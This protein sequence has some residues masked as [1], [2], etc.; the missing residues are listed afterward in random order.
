MGIAPLLVCNLRSVVWSLH[1]S[2]IL[3]KRVQ[4]VFVCVECVCPSV[5]FYYR[6]HLFFMSVAIIASVRCFYDSVSHVSPSS[7]TELN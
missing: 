2:F 5:I 3:T 7:G 4:G 1:L 6:D